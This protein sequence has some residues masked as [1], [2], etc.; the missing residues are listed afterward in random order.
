MIS[1][2]LP[3]PSQ[4]TTAR[5]APSSG[6]WSWPGRP[7]RIANVGAGLSLVFALQVFAIIGASAAVIVAVVIALIAA[8][9]LGALVLA[10]VLLGAA[11]TQQIVERFGHESVVWTARGRTYV[12]LSRGRPDDLDRVVQYVKAS[13]Q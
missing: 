1:A 7:D 9:L 2:G 6:A 3:A 12:V 13:V 8:F 4:W 10:L 5:P 11:D